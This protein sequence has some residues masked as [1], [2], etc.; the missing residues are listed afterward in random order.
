MWAAQSSGGG[1]SR[2][3]DA[4]P[5]RVLYVEDDEAIR[6]CFCHVLLDAGFEVDAVDTAEAAAERLSARTYDV[7]LTDLSLP[8]ESGAWLLETARRNGTLGRAAPMVVTA[9]TGSVPVGPDVPILRKPVEFDELIVQVGAAARRGAHR[10]FVLFL[11]DCSASHRA[12]RNLRA[13]LGQSA[14][15]QRLPID[16]RR[17]NGTAP[18]AE[19]EALR[20]REVP[21]LVCRETG[22]RLIGDLSDLERV[23]DFVSGAL[24]RV[25]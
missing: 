21:V 22:G 16:V 13:F 14:D 11:T 20:I 9:H 10:G 6:E 15:H 23:S 5:A 25:H 3:S 1:T 19:L 4:P 18:A 24:Q 12:E 7:V 17:L 8:G 2:T